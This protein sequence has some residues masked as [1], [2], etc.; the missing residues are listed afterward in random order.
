MVCVCMCTHLCVGWGGVGEGEEAGKEA[1]ERVNIVPTSS[2]D[3]VL[4][5]LRGNVICGGQ[6]IGV[7]RCTHPAEWTKAQ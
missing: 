5:Y 2:I 3:K 6:V 7:T 4:Q 1:G